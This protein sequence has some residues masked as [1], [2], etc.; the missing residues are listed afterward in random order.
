[1]AERYKVTIEED[2]DSSIVSWIIVIVL[3]VLCV[4]Y[5][6]IPLLICYLLYKLIKYL[7]K[8]NKSAKETAYLKCPSCGKKDALRPFKEEVVYNKP[9]LLQAHSKSAGFHSTVRVTETCVRHFDKC[10]FCGGIHFVDVINED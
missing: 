7:I 5:V 6:G 9:K 1:M 8:R 10:R 2:N 3:G 4:I